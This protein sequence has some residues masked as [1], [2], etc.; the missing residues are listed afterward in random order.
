MSANVIVGARV[1]R[2]VHAFFLLLHCHTSFMLLLQLKVSCGVPT[3]SGD[4]AM[5]QFVFVCSRAYGLFGIFIALVLGRAVS[6]S[7]SEQG[8]VEP[9]LLQ[10][11][12]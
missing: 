4:V 9:F 7:S 1:E 12:F 6:N 8:E 5:A 3:H 10:R 11:T 2:V